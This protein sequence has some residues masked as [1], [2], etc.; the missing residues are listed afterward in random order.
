MTLSA[1]FALFLIF[2]SREWIFSRA[3]ARVDLP[4]RRA[5]ELND[6]TVPFFFIRSRAAAI[7]IFFA[8]AIIAASFP[9]WVSGFQMP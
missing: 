1:K 2:G 5:A 9:A 7:H 4:A 3:K 8:R 6:P